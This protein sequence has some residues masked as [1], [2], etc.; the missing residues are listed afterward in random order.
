MLKLR[1]KDITVM[2]HL[3]RNALSLVW[4]CSVD[5]I[6]PIQ[7]MS[8]FLGKDEIGDR[9]DY[10][11]DEGMLT[12]DM[13]VTSRGR[14]ALTVVMCGGVFDVVHHGHVHA[15]NAAKALGDVLVVVVAS[16]ATVKKTKKHMHHDACTRRRI[17][18]AIGVV[19][20]CLVGHDSDIFA[21]VSTVQPDIIALG[22]DQTHHIT[23]IEA[24]CR[25]LGLNTSVVRLESPMPDVTSSDL[26]KD[27][28]LDVM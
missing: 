6:D 18:G 15:L 20:V 27:I 10:L 13:R 25:R 9:L 14:G 5:R 24:G 28:S 23:H 12:G 7:E 8:K 22:Y 1:P 19:D 3:Q 2:N 11:I 21:S 26:K 4:A 17:V 16:D